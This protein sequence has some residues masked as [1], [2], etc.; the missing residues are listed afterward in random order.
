ILQLVDQGRLALEQPLR[1]LLPQLDLPAEITAGQLLRHRS[2]LANHT[3]LPDYWPDRMRGRW[4]P[5]Q[6]LNDMLARPLLFAP[7]SDCAYSNT[8]YALLARLAETVGGQPFA[9][10]LRQMLDSLGLS[11]IQDEMAS[12]AADA[13]H[14]YWLD[15]A[16][17]EAE[18]LDISNGYGA[19][20]LSAAAPGLL[21]WWR[22]AWRGD[23]LSPASR[24]WMFATEDGADDFAA[25]WH[26]E[27]GPQ[28]PLISH[29][30]DVN[31][32]IAA[33]YAEPAQDRCVIVLSNLAQTDA[34]ALAET[35]AGLLDG[36][37]C[38][39]PGLPAPELTLPAWTDGDYLDAE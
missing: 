15:S 30:G 2:G 39:A 1:P 25:G 5:D 34:W 4:T 23:A 7:G 37:E 17:T 36:Q 31:G 16:W 11:S 24:D 32:F 8:G 12:P 27:H 26:R 13:A 20:S 29:I 19:Y 21:R 35:M 22:A 14:G 38:A 33:L 10:Q 18:P 3:A 28:G 9:V 6:L